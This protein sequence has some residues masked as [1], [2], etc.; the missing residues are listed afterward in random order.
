MKVKRMPWFL[1]GI[2]F[3]TCISNSVCINIKY[4]ARFEVL[5]ATLLRCRYSGMQKVCHCMSRSRHF[6]GSSY[7]EDEGNTVLYTYENYSPHNTVSN[8]SKLEYSPHKTSAM[9]LTLDLRYASTADSSHQGLTV[10]ISKRG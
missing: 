5:T 3:H 4:N 9:T 1:Y 2:C 10:T 7:S 6:V 8:H